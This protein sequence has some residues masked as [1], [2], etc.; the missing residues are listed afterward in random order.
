[1]IAGWDDELMGLWKDEITLETGGG[2]VCGL[3]R[4]FSGLLSWLRHFSSFNS[5]GRIYI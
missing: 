1:M 5:I 2:T 4:S 3:H